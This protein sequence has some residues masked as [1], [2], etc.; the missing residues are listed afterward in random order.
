[1]HPILHQQPR[2]E[3]IAHVL[4]KAPADR[5]AELGLDAAK[6]T[7]WADLAYSLQSSAIDY[8]PTSSVQSMDVFC[9]TP[10]TTV[11]RD[12]ED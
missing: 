12:M 11:A 4:S 5:M 7:N 10:L 9:A 8:E 6:L 1:M 2:E 3:V